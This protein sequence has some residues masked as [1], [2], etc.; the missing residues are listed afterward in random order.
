MNSLIAQKFFILNF[1]AQNKFKQMLHFS[2]K[3]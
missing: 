2:S 1:L 3:K